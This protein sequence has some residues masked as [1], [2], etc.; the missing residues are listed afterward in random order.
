MIQKHVKRM[1]ENS[2]PKQDPRYLT[3]VEKGFRVL[4]AL[5]V[6][7]GPMSLTEISRKTELTVP[8]LQRLTS[9]LV[10]AGYVQKE[11]SSKR[12]RPTVKTVDLLFSYLS[13][14]QF[15]NRAWPHLVKLRE[16]LGL[17]VSLSVPLG[18]SMIYVHRLPGYSGNFENTLPGKKVPMHYSASGRCILS[19]KS[20]DEIESYVSAAEVTPLTPWS[21]S[22]P[23]ELVDEIYLCR[24]R[25]Y[26][27]VKQEASPGIMTIA[28]PVIR[29]GEAFAGISVHVPAAGTAPASF[30]DKVLLPVVL[31]SQALSSG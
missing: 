20:R 12:Y 19:Q 16:D 28:C 27:L 3:S 29:E 7:S 5:S 4:D 6:N 11:M 2:D 18:S 14:N 1:L 26:A 30:I 15:A 13:R 22:N 9:T 17:D 23:A 10:E 25:G 8:T 21:I 24:E 31:V